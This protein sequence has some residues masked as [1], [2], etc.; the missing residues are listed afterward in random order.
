MAN[1]INASYLFQQKNFTQVGKRG[2]KNS[3]NE[4]KDF[5]TQYS[6]NFSV[7]LSNKGLSAL[8]QQKNSVDDAGENLTS[9]M[10]AD[11]KKLSAT[12]QDFLK[13]LR[14]KYGDYDFVIAD[15]MSDPQ[16]L[17]KDNTKSYS[18]ILSTEEIER[19]ATDE[20]Y[21]A[22]VM[23]HVDS[24]VGKMDSI[25]EKAELEDGVQFTSL[26][27]SIDDEGNMKLFASIE[28]ISEEQ[29][30]RLEKAKEKRAEDAEDEKDS[31]NDEKLP[32][33]SQKVELE[34]D[35]VEEML[36]KIFG[37]KWDEISAQTA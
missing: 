6:S 3:L 7:E 11:E 17:T 32:A 29:Q 1:A 23:G 15:D 25:L 8:A 34:A 26:S 4:T 12:A 21:A 19:M 9:M 18:V 22:K 30:E 13:T 31:D 16:S 24:A 5:A 28:K 2:G 20:E 27:A 36:E 33:A 37:I 10:T 35:S 14:E